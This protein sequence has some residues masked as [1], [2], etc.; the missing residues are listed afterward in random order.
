MIQGVF[1]I[2]RRRPASCSSFPSLAAWVQFDSITGQA[3]I[4]DHDFDHVPSLTC[5]SSTRP[6]TR[7]RV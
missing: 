1:T 3:L 5:P 2:D 7:R 6:S 4:R